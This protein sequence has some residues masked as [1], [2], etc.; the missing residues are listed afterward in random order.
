VATELIIGDLR[1]GR[2]LLDLPFETLDWSLIR[3]AAGTIRVTIPISSRL[4]QKLGLG[5][6]TTEAKTFLCVVE[7]DVPLEAGPIWRRV[8]NEPTR[9]LELTAGGLW[10]YFD[11]RQIIPLLTA[12][13]PVIDPSTGESAA[14]A[15]TDLVGW[16]YGTIAKKLLQQSEQW[17][18]GNLPIVYAADEAGTYE[19]HY[20]GANLR[21]IGD[22]LRA[23]VDLVDGVDIRFL[24]RRTADRLGIE[25][26]LQTGTIAAPEIHAAAVNVWDYSVA[27]PSIRNLRVE[28]DASSMAGQAWA[29]G[30]RQDGVAVI[31]RARNTALINAGYPLLEAVDSAHADASESAT[32]AAYAANAV[33]LGAAPENAWSFEVKAV[34]VPRVGSYLPGD[35]ADIKIAGDPWIPDGTYRREIATISGDQAGKWVKV[36]TEET[37]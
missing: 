26:V 6:A 14:Y 21:K 22:E 1:T 12:S 28:S 27:R 4:V 34:D 9:K 23:L 10:T 36:V 11:H 35:Y 5:N 15:N 2:R 25:W 7:N 13:Q 33:R 3:N 19:R 31:E 37:F 32:L 24:P 17:T 16:S 8:Y 30:G 29:S 18:G 20:L